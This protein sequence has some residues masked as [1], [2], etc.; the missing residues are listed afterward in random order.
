MH[1]AFYLSAGK[2]WKNNADKS[3]TWNHLPADIQ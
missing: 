3:V 2:V 1:F